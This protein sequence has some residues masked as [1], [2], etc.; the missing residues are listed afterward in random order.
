[1]NSRNIKNYWIFSADSQRCSADIY[2]SFTKARDQCKY[3]HGVLGKRFLQRG[4]YTPPPSVSTTLFLI[5]F[6][7]GFR[8]LF[9][10]FV[11]FLQ[12]LDSFFQSLIF[13]TEYPYICFDSPIA[14][15]LILVHPAV[16][17]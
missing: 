12:L 16:L 10:S 3:A 8:H 14:F 5:R 15:F 6:R 2:P 11:L 9:Q 4:Q 17:H 13:A 1:M 7:L